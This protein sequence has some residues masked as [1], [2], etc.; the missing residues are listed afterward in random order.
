MEVSYAVFGFGHSAA[1]AVQHIGT[2]L[3][4]NDAAFSLNDRNGLLITQEYLVR[5]EPTLSL[6]PIADLDNLIRP[7]A[8][9]VI[10]LDRSDRIVADDVRRIVDASTVSDTSCLIVHIASANPAASWRATP[11]E[12][13]SLHAHAVITMM[14][15]RLYIP[16]PE[17]IARSILSLMQFAMRGKSR[18]LFAFCDLADVLWA[19]QNYACLY[20]FRIP[21][22]YL[23]DDAFGGPFQPLVTTLPCAPERTYLA[24]SGCEEGLL[25]YFEK[26][27][28]SLANTINTVWSVEHPQSAI[29]PTVFVDDSLGDQLEFVTCFSLPYERLAFQTQQ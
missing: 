11:V 8:L 21:A 27:H 16:L 3:S 15:S 6:R 2:M 20:V 4:P 18:A 7:A 24:V 5:P 28:A 19:I 12:L 25:D 17:Q 13:L 23:R 10:V 14:A 9:V 26:A 22:P 1:Q 29:V